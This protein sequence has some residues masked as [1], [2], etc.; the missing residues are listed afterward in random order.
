MAQRE[1]KKNVKEFEIFLTG[2]DKKLFSNLDVEN[3][4]QC[5]NLVLEGLTLFV[6]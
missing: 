4:I 1:M 5:E 6:D 2:G 3:I